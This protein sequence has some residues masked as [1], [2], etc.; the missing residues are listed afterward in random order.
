MDR[1]A[2]PEVITRM[3]NSPAYKTSLLSF[4]ETVLI[5][6]STKLVSAGYIIGAEPLYCNN[7]ILMIKNGIELG[8]QSDSSA[9]HS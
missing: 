2:S 8:P 4:E 3:H 1:G 5:S 6:S 7:A 9:V